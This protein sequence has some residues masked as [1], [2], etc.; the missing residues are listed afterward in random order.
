MKR[1]LLPLLVLVTVLW[2]G[3]GVGMEIAVRMIDQPPPTCLEFSTTTQTPI[4]TIPAFTL[5]PAPPGESPLA[6]WKRTKA[7]WD[8]ANKVEEDAIGQVQHSVAFPAIEAYTAAEDALQKAQCDKVCV[9][10]KQP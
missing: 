10:E 8:R 1:W 7:D 4:V 5:T 6:R 9:P 3:I 2:V